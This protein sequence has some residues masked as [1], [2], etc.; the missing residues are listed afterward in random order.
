MAVF[1]D[2]APCSLVDIDWCFRGA[3]CLHH[4][5]DEN[6]TQS[7]YSHHKGCF[8]KDGSNVYHVF[9]RAE[10]MKKVPTNVGPQMTSEWV[11]SICV[12]W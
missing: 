4:Q 8:K 5:G 2:V 6:L 3:Y 10:L 12:Y 1:W 11:M 7:E 9:Q